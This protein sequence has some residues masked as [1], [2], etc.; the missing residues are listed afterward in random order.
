MKSRFLF[1]CFILFSS[2]SVSLT[3]IIHFLRIDFDFENNNEKKI[4][5]FEIYPNNVLK[6]WILH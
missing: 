3:L 5:I 4:E 6:N 1:S 2:L